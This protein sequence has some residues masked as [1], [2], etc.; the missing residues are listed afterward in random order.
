[1]LVAK[2]EKFGNGV[3]VPAPAAKLRDRLEAGL[4]HL[5]AYGCSPLPATAAAPRRCA[6][7][8]I[9]RT[10]P[11]LVAGSQAQAPGQFSP[12]AVRNLCFFSQLSAVTA[13]G[14]VPGVWSRW[15]PRRFC[16][17]GIYQ[18]RNFR[19]I[20]DGQI[21][22]QSENSLLIWRSNMLGGGTPE[23][24]RKCNEFQERKRQSFYIRVW[25]NISQFSR[26]IVSASLQPYELQHTRPPCP[27]PTPGIHSD[28]RPSS[29]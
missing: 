20:P 9:P 15:S 5:S 14:S 21:L 3:G 1:M 10:A 28:S 18:G 26:S 2:G 19:S 27:S 8:I 6:G 22:S 4:S 17:G 24:L 29:Q 11:P 13:P 7:L 12:A 25:K 23:S 16:S